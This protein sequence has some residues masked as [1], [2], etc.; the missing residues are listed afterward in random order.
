MYFR[1][2]CSDGSRISQTIAGGTQLLDLGQTP[3]ISQE[4]SQKL[5]ENER[6]LDLEEGARIPSAP[7]PFHTRQ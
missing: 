6:K 2:I 3:I 1:R 4:F 5:D 7:H